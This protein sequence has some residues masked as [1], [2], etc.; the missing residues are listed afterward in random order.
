MCLARP[1]LEMPDC[2]ER[3]ELFVVADIAVDASEYTS[4]SAKS[5]S[6]ERNKCGLD[7]IV[8]FFPYQIRPK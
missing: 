6:P 4:D 5:G 8:L 3:N 7:R 2:P 1:R